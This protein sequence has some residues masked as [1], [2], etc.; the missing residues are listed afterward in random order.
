MVIIEMRKSMSKYY[1][2]KENKSTNLSPSGGKRN[3]TSTAPSAVILCDFLKIEFYL[4][5]HF[6]IVQLGTTLSWVVCQLVK[7]FPFY[8]KLEPSLL[9]DSI[10][11]VKSDIHASITRK[12][13]SLK[14][15]VIF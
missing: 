4:L 2:L 3:Q 13:Q 7:S 5:F 14:I 8:L 6:V 10:F 1:S 11:E 15:R 12:H 9:I